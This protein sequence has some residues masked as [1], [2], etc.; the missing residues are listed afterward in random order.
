[1]ILCRP[2]RTLASLGLVLLAACPGEAPPPLPQQDSGE[3]AAQVQRVSGKTMDYFGNMALAGVMLATDGIN[4]PLMAS[5]DAEGGFV[6]DEI[7]IG[8]QIFF[9]VGRS[10]YRPTRNTPVTVADAA[11]VQDLYLMS[12]ADINRQYTTDGKVPTNGR[13][14]VIAELQRNNGMP[15]DGIPLIDVKLV[16]GVGAPAAGVIGP[17]VIGA[18]GDITPAATATETHGGKARVAFLDV[19]PGTFALKVTYLDGQQQ[20]Q[21]ITTS[22]T[23]IADGATLV[24]SGGMGGMGGGNGGNP[25]NPKFVQD[26]YPSLQTAANGGIGCAGCHGPGLSGAIMVV[27][28]LAADVLAAL[29]AKPGLID[30]AAPANSLL[31]TKPLYELPPA[32][33]NHPNATFIDVN[34]PLYK[35]ILLWI[36]QGALP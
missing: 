13:A 24:R 6:F 29:L 26:I 32:L 30:L 5:S 14:F 18:L 8:S 31:L 19:P 35:K 34:D 33:Q 16:D 2:M 7:P 17:Y 25:L 27:N 36:Q 12:N 4:P 15:Q 28:A 1:L 23:T 9:S 3:V 20:Q 21:T 11:V 22:V 10:G